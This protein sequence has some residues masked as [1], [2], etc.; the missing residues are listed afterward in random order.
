MSDYKNCTAGIWDVVYY[1]HDEEGEPILNPDGSVKLFKDY[2]NVDTST[3]S[4]WVD[5]EI[6]EEI[7]HLGGNKR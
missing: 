4:E 6:L 5:P 3:W 7:G 2:G 1:L